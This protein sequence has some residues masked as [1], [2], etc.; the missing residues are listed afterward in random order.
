MHLSSSAATP[1]A[2]PT[3][4]P[5]STLQSTPTA[6][7]SSQPVAQARQVATPSASA[8][9]AAGQPAWRWPVDGQI[10]RRFSAIEGGS[11]GIDIAG[12]SGDPVVA[13]A[14]GRVVYAGSG[15]LGYG[16]L[17]I[18]NHNRQFLSAYA[19]NSRILV[20]ENDMVKSG[21]KIA[22]M[23]QTGTDRV[24]LH[25]EIRRDGKPV[26]PLTYLPKP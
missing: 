25:F 12:K 14:D 20:S 26:D 9:P 3:T 5:T 13:A 8:A 21:T 2:T 17:V 18:I 4:T 24:Q 1:G 22:E 15:L 23:G 19:H 6:P 10:I 16:N 7:P 11:K